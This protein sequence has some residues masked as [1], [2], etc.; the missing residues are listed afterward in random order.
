MPNIWVCRTNDDN[1]K[2]SLK[3]SVACFG[4]AIEN[5]LKFKSLSEL[6]LAIDRR[7]GDYD[8]GFITGRTFGKQLWSISHETRVGDWIYL[9][10]PNI[11]EKPR[12]P[13]LPKGKRN[14]QRSFIVAAGIITGAYTYQSKS[15]WQHQVKV[16]WQWQGQELIDYGFQ[17]QYYVLINQSA[18]PN[19]HAA[20]K[21]V[22]TPGK[23]VVSKDL[24]PTGKAPS[25][26][27]PEPAI[28]LDRDWEEGEAVLRQHLAIER[29]QAASKFAKEAAR[30]RGKGVIHCDACGMAPSKAYGEEIIEAHHVIPLA[31]TKGMTRT[32]TPDDFAMLCPNCHRA[33]HRVL[34]KGIDQGRD[35]IETVRKTVFSH[36]S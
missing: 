3:R 34:A 27:N 16:D 24:Q 5:P 20:L 7:L 21:A 15:D 13:N 17:S 33:V 10:H 9:D 4:L 35:A 19:V 11:A 23:G 8:P 32:P 31:D 22:W 36:R 26:K 1:Y 6:N 25:V 18:H 29:S 2:Y 30:K 12:D 28:S 14:P